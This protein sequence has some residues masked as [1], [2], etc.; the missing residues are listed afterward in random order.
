MD[1]Q[2]VDAAFFFPTL[3]VG[4]QASLSDDVE[5]MTTAFHA[6]NQWI[7]DDWGFDDGRI[8]GAPLLTLAD[9]DQAVAEVDWA[10]DQGAK[11]MVMV[12]GPVPMPDGTRRSPGDPMF[13]PVW[14]RINEAGITVGIHGGDGG[15]VT[16]YV[17][18]WERKDEMEA[19]RSTPFQLVV[20]HDRQIGDTFAAMICHGLFARHPNLR[21]ASI[22]NGGSFVHGLLKELTTAYGKMPQEFPGDLHPVEQF[23]KHVWVSPYYEDDIDE[24]K[25]LIGPDHVLF[26]SDWPHAEGLAEPTAFVHDIPN[27]ASDEVRMIM[28]DNAFDLVRPQA[29]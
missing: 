7:L 25:E 5:A 4:M 1:E 24:I 14:A 6:F 26:G 13:D 12:P 18:N 11:I 8:Y 20:T 10:L 19:F 21:I 16:E 17:N 22:E 29:A 15:V 9:V 27:F 23:A 2:G 28:R 3:A